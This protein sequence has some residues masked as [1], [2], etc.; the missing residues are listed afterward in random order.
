ML[1]IQVE[2]NIADAG[3]A[4]MLDCGGFVAETNATNIVSVCLCVLQLSDAV[5]WTCYLS[6]L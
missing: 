6:N 5:D 1:L 4:L 2:G 3:D